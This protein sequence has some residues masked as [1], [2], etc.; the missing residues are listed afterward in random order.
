[1]LDGKRNIAV[2]VAVVILMTMVAVSCSAPKRVPSGSI[3]DR[4]GEDARKRFDMAYLEAINQQENDNYAA[5]FD[6]LNY[7]LSIDSLSPAVYDMLSAYYFEMGNNEKGMQYVGKAYTLNPQNE[8]YAERYARSMVV[9]KKFSEA[10]KIYEGLVEHD[11]SRTDILDVLAQIYDVVG[12]NEGALRT[13]DRM[14]TAEGSSEE[15]TMAKMFIYSKQGKKDMEFAE[16]RKLADK[17]PYDMKYRVMMGNWL[18]QNE[19][20]G[21]AYDEYMKVLKKEP[22]NIA[23]R[24]SLI[25]YYQA[26]GNDSVADDMARELIFDRKNDTETRVSLIRGL[27]ANHEQQQRDSTEILK[28]LDTLMAGEPTVADFAIMKAAYMSLKQMPQE[29]INDVNRQILAVSPDY[30]PARFRLVQA[31]WN[32][33]SY[34]EVI[35]LCKAGNEYN[36]DDMAFY[37]FLGMAYSQ[38]DDIDQSLDAF[39]RGVS[40]INSDSNADIV[41]DFYGMMGDLL[42]EKGEIEKAFAA[43]DSCL[44]WKD[45]NYYC[46]NN[47]AYFLALRGEQ[48]ER[49]EAMSYKTIQAE[50]K[51][52][53]YLDTYAWVLF[54]RGKYE[55]AKTYIDKMMEEGNGGSAVEYEHAGDIYYMCGLTDEAV[56]FWKKALEQN[57]DNAVVREKI[58]QRKYIETISK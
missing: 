19:R 22:D 1:M 34:D 43:Y 38:K 23:A 42:H 8:Y 28:M 6:L 47:Y 44:H 49:A 32:T 18:M 3:A 39:Q 35:S 41:S 56:E 57:R 26:E 14:E 7:C 16:L 21:E 36:P 20:K 10:A 29:S 31:L 53:T 2:A 25:D 4:I 50:P 9:D 48:L 52:G 27:I 24:L 54:M 55:E 12:D 11:H 33:E 17:H 40:Q 37:Y 15:I 30:S 51:N 13:L 5:A 45:D 46:M 58:R